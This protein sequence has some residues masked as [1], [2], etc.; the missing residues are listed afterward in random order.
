MAGAA[1]LMTQAAPSDKITLGVIG[2]G[3]PGTFVMRIFQVDPFVRVGAIG[4]VYAPSSRPP[5]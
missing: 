2:A 3:S 5:W 4:G 1:A